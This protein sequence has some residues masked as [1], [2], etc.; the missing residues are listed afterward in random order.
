M[1]SPGQVY[2]ARARAQ[3]VN[4]RNSAGPMISTGTFTLRSCKRL[5]E[6]TVTSN[7][8]DVGYYLSGIF[9]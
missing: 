1:T 5:V 2:D 6:L 9:P 3:A 8:C 4:T 7:N